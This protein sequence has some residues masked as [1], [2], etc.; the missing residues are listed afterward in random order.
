[1]IMTN[2]I[3]S[4]IYSL[5]D[6]SIKWNIDDSVLRK[7]ISNGKLVKGKDVEKYGKQWVVTIEAMERVYGRISNIT[8]N[9]EYSPLKKRQIYYY[10]SE[11]LTLFKKNKNISYKE[12]SNLF[13]QYNIFAYLYD[14]FDY[15]HLGD[16]QDVVKEISSRIRRKL[17]YE[18]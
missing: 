12:S 5:K 17:S 13:N 14:C 11:L 16:I 9:L 6:A 18:R 7:A 1:M 3:F 10:Q 15:L 2:D 8:N 4:K